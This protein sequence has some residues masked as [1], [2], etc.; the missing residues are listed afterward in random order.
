MSLFFYWILRNLFHRVYEQL[1]LRV[2]RC[3]FLLYTGSWIPTSFL[4]SKNY[5]AIMEG[6]NSLYNSQFQMN[7]KFR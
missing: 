4:P 1:I 2:K 5:T 3:N 7:P 6:E